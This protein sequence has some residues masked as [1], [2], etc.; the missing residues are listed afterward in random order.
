MHVLGRS[1]RQARNSVNVALDCPVFHGQGSTTSLCL[2]A[3]I[4]PPPTLPWTP[5]RS[6][7][8]AGSLHHSQ[9][10]NSPQ[11]QLFHKMPLLHTTQSP[12]HPTLLG[13]PGT[14]L[15]LHQQT[16]SR[17]LTTTMPKTSNT[18][19]TRT[20]AENSCASMSMASW[21]TRLASVHSQPTYTISSP[22]S[23]PSLTQCIR[24]STPAIARAGTSLAPAMISAHG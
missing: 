19:R 1:W 15:E 8:V 6:R 10:E 11:P 22:S 16:L 14:T 12:R 2:V 5:K 7:L 9:L 21:A 17:R 18:S 24:K 13:P 3:G 4:R 20:A 23:S